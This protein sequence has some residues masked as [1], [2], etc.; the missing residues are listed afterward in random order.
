MLQHAIRKIA[1]T[2]DPYAPYKISQ[3]I[4]A[5][6]FVF[7]SGQAALDLH[8]NLVGV[9][10]FEAQAEQAFR[11]LATV[12]EAAGSSLAR[13]I[14]VT[15]YVTDI[16]NFPVIVRLREKWFSPPYP[17]DTIVQIEQLALPELQIEIDAVALAGSGCP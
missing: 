7:V 14:K 4:E 13:V 16:V 17:A 8:G 10:D 11:M 15:I 9:G 2:P 5:G 3:A 1:T 6:G 12:L